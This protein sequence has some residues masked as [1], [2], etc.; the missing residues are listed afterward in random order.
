M[1][2]DEIYQTRPMSRTPKQDGPSFR[3]SVRSVKFNYSMLSKHEKFSPSECPTK[4]VAECK[5]YGLAESLT[6]GL[7]DTAVLSGSNLST[8]KLDEKSKLF[9]IRL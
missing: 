5:D 3:T 7:I 9:R 2:C 4:L 1:S 6:C 8:S